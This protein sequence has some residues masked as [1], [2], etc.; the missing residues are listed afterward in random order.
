[1][2]FDVV[3]NTEDSIALKTTDPCLAKWALLIS[4]VHNMSSQYYLLKFERFR[5]KESYPISYSSWLKSSIT[6][7][8]HLC[9]ASKRFEIN[10]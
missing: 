2:S 9:L 10:P 8:H 7:E 4:K 5:F 1:M 6:V 3:A